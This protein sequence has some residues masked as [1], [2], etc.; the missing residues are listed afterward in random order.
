MS[1]LALPW[2]PSSIMHHAPRIMHHVPSITHHETR[3]MHQPTSCLLCAHRKFLCIFNLFLFCFWLSFLSLHVWWYGCSLVA[4][5]KCENDPHYPACLHECCTFPHLLTAS[6]WRD[7]K[8]YVPHAGTNG[9][10][11]PDLSPY[12]SE[13]PFIWQEELS[14]PGIVSPQIIFHAILH[15]EQGPSRCTAIGR[16]AFALGNSKGIVGTWTY[17]KS[18]AYNGTVTQLGSNNTLNLYRRERPHLI[19]NQQGRLTHLTNGVQISADNDR[20]WTLVQPLGQWYFMLVYAEDSGLM[21]FVEILCDN[22]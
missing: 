17:S 12:G 21:V 13:D 15:D 2:P 18:N 14:L 9:R 5:S 8:T 3:T 11:F 20:S 10:I 6:N 1:G 22:T 7:P 4:S 16:H 19:I